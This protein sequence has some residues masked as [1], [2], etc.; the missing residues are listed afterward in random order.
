M[1][2]W[3]SNMLGRDIPPAAIPPKDAKPST[4]AFAGWGFGGGRDNAPSK[5]EKN[6]VERGQ[7]VKERPSVKRGAKAS[8]LN[9]RVPLFPETDESRAFSS[10]LDALK[11]YE[12]SLL[13]EENRALQYVPL[14]EGLAVAWGEKVV[15]PR[16]CALFQKGRLRLREIQK[17]EPD[18]MK[19]YKQV[20][21]E[22]LAQIPPKDV[23][24][25][26]QA[27]LADRERQQ[28]VGN[29]AGIAVAPEVMLQNAFSYYLR[30][31]IALDKQKAAAASPVDKAA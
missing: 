27:S 10:V 8:A 29:G 11:A 19:A 20:M 5:K 6:I 17:D 7:K 31:Q 21:T 15:S 28:R 23:E 9:E 16:L 25:I 30:W 3:I 18:I 26:Q 12:L 13:A 24:K 1:F 14:T 4:S 22:M 2:K